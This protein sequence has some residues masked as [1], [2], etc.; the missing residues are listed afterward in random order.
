MKT[1]M[2]RRSVAMLASAGVT[3]AI[4]LLPSA[5]AHASVKAEFQAEGEADASY[6]GP[7][8]GGSCDLTSGHDDVFSPGVTFHHGTKRQ[9]VKLGATFTSSDN[10]ADQV[11]VKGHVNSSLTVKRKGGGLSSLDLTADAAV[12]VSN[13]ES[14]S[15]CRGSGDLL[16]GIQL[17][18]F[19]ESKKG[20]LSIDYT[21]SKPQ[22]LIEFVVF[23]YKTEQ[24]VMEVLNVG[25][26][27]HGTG[28]VTLKPG[29]YAIGE[30]E[31]GAFGG[32]VFAKRASLTHKTS[33]TVE[34]KAAFMPKKH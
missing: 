31:V 10:S 24:S 20:V 13:T 19:T 34:V 29:K 6:V 33:R 4:A 21:T 17:L 12:T 27:T 15:A 30:T 23:S 3:T 1:S 22:A 2:M 14:G 18:N 11:R 8:A 5:A 9:S 28:Q 32:S 7:T 26:H 16:G 25:N